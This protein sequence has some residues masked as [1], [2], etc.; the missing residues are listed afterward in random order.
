MGARTKPDMKALL[1]NETNRAG[2]SR[3][4]S[5][6]LL[7]LG[8]ATALVGGAA[9]WEMRTST[10]QS[11]WFSSLAA[12]I[13]W[14][15][16]PGPSPEISF[17]TGPYDQRVGYSRLPNMIESASVRGFDLVEQARASYRYR[18]LVGEW[19]LFPI[20][21][22]KSQTGLSI[23][24]RQGESLFEA[25]FPVRAYSSFESIPR[26]VWE[27]L[28]F[29]ENRTLLDPDR[30]LKNPAVEWPRLLR[31]SAELGL[32]A[33]GREGSIAGASTLATRIEKFRH[34]PDGLTSSPK[35][36]LAQMASASLRAYLGGPQ[37]LTA[38]R[39]IVLDYLNSVPLAAQRGEGEI[40]GLGDGLWAWYGR[41]LDEVNRVLAMGS[42]S[43]ASELSR[44][45]FASPAHSEALPGSKGTV[46]R[47]VLSLMLS[48]RRPTYYR[49]CTSP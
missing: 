23:I 31:S 44:G 41:E 12:E 34:S 15:V 40:T 49:N 8:L 19:S 16:R 14:Q 20:Y 37:T 46:Y 25:R 45:T 33:L 24:D 1:N 38:R 18:S 5:L 29:V 28:L 26:V 32:R 48:Q 4:G 9:I 47:E 42:S 35:D 13:S 43:H 3:L 36:K 17:P 6:F 39:Q 22:E 21:R 10:L 11:R 7:S 2:R 27:T 30:P